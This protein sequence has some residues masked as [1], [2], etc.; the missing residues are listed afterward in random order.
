MFTCLFSPVD[1][2]DFNIEYIKHR[3]IFQDEI[4]RHTYIR[5]SL[6]KTNFIYNL[7]PYIPLMFF[8]GAKRPTYLSSFLGS[9][10]RLD[11]IYDL[12][13]TLNEAVTRLIKKQFV[14]LYFFPGT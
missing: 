13:E 11:S 14:Y 6:R 10:I 2:E 5:V 4:K 12:Q 3:V 9:V 1:S 8:D 7:H